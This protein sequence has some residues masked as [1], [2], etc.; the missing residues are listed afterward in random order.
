MPV[1]G[2]KPIIGVFNK[3]DR[4]DAEPVLK[5]EFTKTVCISAKNGINIDGLMKTVCETAP[6]QKRRITV[7]IPYSMGSLVNE[8]H[9]NQKVINEEYT[10]DGTKMEL[11]ADSEAYER[12]KEYVTEE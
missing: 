4:L 12:I 1:A 5:G 7:C 6:G 8:L 10:A 3:C 2:G 11:L 9:T